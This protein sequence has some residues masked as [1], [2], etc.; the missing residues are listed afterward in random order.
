MPS[1]VAEAEQH[2]CTVYKI[3]Q[4]VI[5]VK[6]RVY[7]SVQARFA[8][9]YLLN[10]KYEKSLSAIAREYGVDHS[11][12][13]NGVARAIE[14]DIPKELGINPVDKLLNTCG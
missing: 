6:K 4:S 10:M 8:V 5:R 1:V 7:E 13:M 14:L 12:V 2:V 3:D 11:T 9:W